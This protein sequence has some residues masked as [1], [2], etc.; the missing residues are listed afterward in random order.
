MRK[1]VK[2]DYL[3]DQA[4][5]MLRGTHGNSSH[6]TGVRAII[7]MALMEAD[8]YQGFRYL[9]K[10]D[11]PEGITPGVHYDDNGILPDDERFEGTDGTRVEY[12]YSDKK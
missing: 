5:R 1:T 11:L 7:E 12:F 6:R 8:H 2:L 4:N 9:T 3:V 10:F